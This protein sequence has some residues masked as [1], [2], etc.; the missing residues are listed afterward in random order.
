[1]SKQLLDLNEGE[2]LETSRWVL[3]DQSMINA[4]ADATLDHQWIHV[5]E[6]RCKQ[7]SP[8]KTTIGHGL[9]ST[10]LMPALFYDLIAYDTDR[11]ALLNYG[12]DSLRYL[13]PV[14][15]GD[16]IRYHCSLKSR[17][18]KPT[19]QLFSFEASVE[20]DGRDKPA[21]VGTFLMLLVG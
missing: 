19:G 9:L 1:M 8:F 10:S 4:F 15:S 21:M 17:Q 16:R 2:K 14:R 12:I 11:Y 18:Q 5:D 20:I 13:E 3:V 6:E 7:E